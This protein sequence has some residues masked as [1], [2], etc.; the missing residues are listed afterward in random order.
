VNKSPKPLSGFYSPK[1]SSFILRFLE[2]NPQQ[3]PKISDLWDFFPLQKYSALNSGNAGIKA[4]AKPKSSKGR[5]RV[6]INESPHNRLY[7]QLISNEDFPK[8]TAKVD[9]QKMV[10]NS[11]KI[12]NLATSAKVDVKTR[13]ES[14]K[15]QREGLS[16]QQSRESKMGVEIQVE[17]SRKESTGDE[18][19]K[20]VRPQSSNTYSSE[21]FF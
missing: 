1:L 4:D 11:P 21:V 9:D 12:S 6:D 3:R 14:A 5:D 13:P 15:L 20:N 2:K 16:K 7:N 17:N 10:P 18:R 8:E 19:V